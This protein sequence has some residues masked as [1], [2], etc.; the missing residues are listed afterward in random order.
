M[1][2]TTIISTLWLLSSLFISILGILF[3]GN[4]PNYQGGIYYIA[5]SLIFLFIVTVLQRKNFFESFKLSP[6]VFAL[7]VIFILFSSPL[8]ENDHYRYLWEGNALFRGENPYINSPGS[9]ALQHLIYSGKEFISYPHLTTV[10]PPLAI[11]WFGIAGI[12][13]ISIGT[14]VLMV[15]NAMLVFFCFKKLATI[16]KPWMIVAVFPILIKEYIQAV[17]ID[18]LAAVFFLLYMLEKKN[19]FSRNLIFIFLS[20]WIKVLA[21]AGLPFLLFQDEKGIKRNLINILPIFC[22]AAS[23]PLFLSWSIGIDK[24]IGVKEF[25]TDWVWNPGFYSILTRVLNLFDDVARST[26]IY[27]YLAYL[28]VLTLICL[29]KLMNNNWYLDKK[30]RLIMFYLIFSGLMFFTPVYNGWYA[31]WF[32]FP[33]MLLNL[34]SGLFYGIFSVFCYTHYG[35][36]EYH[37]LGESLTHIWFPISLI[38]LT[39]LKKR[40]SL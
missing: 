27:A 13:G 37:W 28:A 2:S 18:L 29:K 17:H 1:K 40:K 21:I 33:A 32:L 34:K 38:E 3:K 12:F 6:F 35:F 31:I 5:Y 10:Y 7:G 4:G 16:T 39:Y 14:K 11:I 22:I 20:I 23:L 24:L 19:K 9:K 25:T 15:M 36:K 26:T 8:Y 30:F